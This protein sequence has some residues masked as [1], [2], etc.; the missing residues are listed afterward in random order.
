[1]RTHEL[2]QCF[3]LI[4]AV[5]FVGALGFGYL[6]DR[7]GLQ[8]TVLASLFI[9]CGVLGYAAFIYE[10]W[11]FWLLGIMIG[12][13]LGGTQ[14]ASRSLMAYLTPA[15]KHAEFFGFYAASGRLSSILG[16]LVYAVVRQATDSARASIIVLLVPF[17]GAI[18]LLWSVDEIKGRLEAEGDRQESQDRKPAKPGT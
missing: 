6:T 16:P 3:L 18:A 7:M 9:W 17:I 12:L 5:A 2:I 1:M 10:K 8:R 4:Q 14:S 11:Q 15:E 13:V